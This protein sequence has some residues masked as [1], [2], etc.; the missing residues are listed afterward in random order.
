MLAAAPRNPSFSTAN[1]HALA[2]ILEAS[3]TKSI[4]A[5][6]DIFDISG[7]KL[8]ARDQPVSSAL[9]R[10]LLDRQLRNPLESCLMAEDGVTVYTLTQTTESLLERDLPITAL[11]RPHAARLVKEIIH[12]PLHSVPQL[13]LTAGQASRPESFEH[14]VQAMA[15]AGALMLQQGGS[16]AEVRVA[17]LAGLLHDL[18]EMYIDPRYG[19]ADADRSLDVLSY[20]QLVVHPHVGHLLIAQLTNYPGAVSRAIAEHHERLDGSGYP[21]GLRRDAV[22]PLGRLLAVTEGALGV[23]RGERAHLSRVSV[24]LRV[25]PGEFDLA[26]V[27]GVEQ[28]ARAQ[29]LRRA[30]H[31]AG[32]VRMRLGRLDVA[33]QAAEARAAAL[34]PQAESPDLKGALEL[35]QHLL[36]RLRTGWNASGLWS[37]DEVAAQDAAE[38]ECVEDELSFR[39]RAVERAAQLRAGELAPRDA[40]LL[41]QLCVELRSLNP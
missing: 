35:A 29:P 31:G 15:L 20:Q 24:A 14:A 34:L 9:Q 40:K 13:L 30:S 27:G 22:S 1:Q 17:M 11:L 23:L 5:S 16:T 8:W 32:E 21:H 36:S 7:I 37:P 25:V 38:V 10:R 6:R 33:L 39:L 12:L 19:E 18:G 28:A 3:Q 2:T 26:W 41:E 4:I